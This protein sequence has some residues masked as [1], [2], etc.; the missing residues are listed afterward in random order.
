MKGT[1]MKFTLRGVITGVVLTTATTL[2]ASCSTNN[3]GTNTD[4]NQTTTTKQL[5]VALITHAVPGDTFW[6]IIR[7]GAEAAALKD[8]VQILYSSDPDGGKQSQLIQQAIDQGVD[9]I[10]TTLAK[11]DALGDVVKKAL[12]SGIPVFSINAGENESK[13]FGVLAH[14]GQNESAAG[15]AVGEQLN[16]EGAKNAICINSDQGQVALEQRCVGMKNTFKGKSEQL[17]VN[18]ADNTSMSSTITAKLQ[19]DPTID[20]VVA[21]GAPIALIAAQSSKDAKSTTKIGSFDVDNDSVKAVEAKIIDFLVDQQPYLQGYEGIDAVWLY[22][23]NGNILGGGAPVFTG[24][25]IITTDNIK[26]VAKFA[27]NGTR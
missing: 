19:T 16:K 26:D 12:A 27:A 1:K 10:V 5:K 24:P 21:P 14:Y 11:P 9:G 22:I 2:L 13:Q 20:F 17:Y 7:K 25:S 23:N 3:N 6:D 4:T 15:E 18:G 8:N